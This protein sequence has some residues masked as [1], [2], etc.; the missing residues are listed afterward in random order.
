MDKLKQVINEEVEEPDS[1]A[2]LAQ[3]PAGIERLRTAMNGGRPLCFPDDDTLSRFQEELRQADSWSPAKYDFAVYIMGSAANGFSMNP[4]KPLKPWQPPNSEQPSDIDLAVCSAKC[5][6]MCR[7][8]RPY[9]DRPEFDFIES[10]DFYNK[11][12]FGKWLS[13]FA[14]K[15][16]QEL[17]TKLSFKLQMNPTIGPNLKSDGAFEVIDVGN[18]QPV[19]DGPPLTQARG[20]TIVRSMSKSLDYFKR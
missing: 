9:R 8:D 13:T 14:D 18:H 12:A 2:W 11:M 4:R 3:H 10:K 6:M 15:W 1:M 5:S 19:H 20:S 7:G 16:G 17:G